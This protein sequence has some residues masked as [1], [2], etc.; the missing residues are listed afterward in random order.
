[1]TNLTR[2]RRRVELV[3]VFHPSVARALDRFPGLLGGR[4]IRVLPDERAFA[5]A[6][7]EIEVLFAINPPRGRWGSAS[8]LRLVQ[9]GSVGVDHLL[10]A[11]GLPASVVIANAAGSTSGPMAEYVVGQLLFLVKRFAAAGENQRRRRWA[12]HAPGVLAGRRVTV[13][14]YGPVGS[15]VC[16]LL[17]PFSV[18]LSVVVRRPRP[19]EGAPRVYGTDDLL[20]VLR[21]TDDLVLALPRTPATRGIIGAAELETMPRHG[22]VVNV[23]RGGLV[24]EDA[25]VTALR[26][27]ELAGA[28]LD[29]VDEEPPGA[30]SPLWDCPDL[31]L[32]GHSSWT[33]PRRDEEIVRTL[34]T[35]LDRLET[36]RPL[37][38][39]V[40][41]EHGYPVS[42]LPAGVGACE[43]GAR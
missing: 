32:G 6:L 1:M 33:T 24:D 2:A 14:G 4:R 13:L 29:T 21:E 40:D 9:L 15:R 11:P 34:A 41:R 42:P 38:N 36:G 39:S 28:A 43:G 7:P 27:G 22:H 16:A 20:G 18:E 12:M 8:R 37:I 23:A 30:D 5:D 17:A 26:A 19:V 31:F 10:P 3:H 35:N 25:L